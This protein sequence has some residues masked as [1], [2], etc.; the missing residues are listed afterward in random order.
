[1]IETVTERD[2]EDEGDRKVINDV[3]EHG[4]HVVAIPPEDDTP[5]WEFSIGMYKTLAHPEIAVF[6]LKQE[7]AHSLINEVGQRV[8]NGAT[9]ER[10]AELSDL[11]EGVRCTFK[12]DLPKWYRPFFG[13]ATWYYKGLNFPVMQCIWP[14]H[15]QKYPWDPRFRSS[16]LW[17]QPLLFH[18]SVES[19]RAAALLATIE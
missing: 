3:R 16:W 18:E 15:D 19:A 9:V 11:L 17:A 4:W 8:K 1:M 14:D 7:V 10:D 5:G 13:T 12:T 2:I 6:G